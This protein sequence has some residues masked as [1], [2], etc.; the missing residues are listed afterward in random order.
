MTFSY[1]DEKLN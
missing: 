1:N